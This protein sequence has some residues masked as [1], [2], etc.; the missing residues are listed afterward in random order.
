[1]RRVF[2]SSRRLLINPLSSQGGGGVINSE[3]VTSD[4][5]ERTY[6]HSYQ[7]NYESNV[8]SEK[9]I[10]AV[11]ST[12]DQF[13]ISNENSLGPKQNETQFKSW[14]I[15]ETKKYVKVYPA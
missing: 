1:M 4:C 5:N 8:S 14:K 6:E 10:R 15:T 13:I 11:S 7:L 2:D 3:P 12:T 9:T